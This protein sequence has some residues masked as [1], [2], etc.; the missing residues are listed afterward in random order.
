M[1]NIVKKLKNDSAFKAYM[2][3][4]FAKIDLLDSVEGLENYSNQTAGEEARVRLKAKQTLEKILEPFINF[5]EKKEP[6][7]EE[8]SEAKDKYGL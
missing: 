5:A 7:V 1:D 4:V 6:T 8:I 3:Y 2:E